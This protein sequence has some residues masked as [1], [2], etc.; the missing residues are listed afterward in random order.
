MLER[1]EEEV[2]VFFA[3]DIEHNSVGDKFFAE[4]IQFILKCPA[5][6]V[7]MKVGF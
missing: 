1:L 3:V 2:A 4:L 6:D 7:A 5:A